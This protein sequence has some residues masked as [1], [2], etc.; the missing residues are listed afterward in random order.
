MIVSERERGAVVTEYGVK[1]FA[2]FD[3]GTGRCPLREPHFMTQLS[4]S[5]AH[6]YNR[7]FAT[8]PGKTTLGTLGHVRG[9]SQSDFRL[10]IERQPP[11][12]FE[13]CDETGGL[14]NTDTREACELLDARLAQ[15]TKIAEFREQMGG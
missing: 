7:S 11:S 12:E 9:A 6:E 8:E 4:T 2:H 14:R 1:D 13:P 3:W 15:S 5:I 10:L